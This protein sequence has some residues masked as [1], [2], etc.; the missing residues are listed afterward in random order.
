MS[1][2]PALF[3]PVRLGDD[4]PGS[5]SSGWSEGAGSFEGMAPGEQVAWLPTD[6]ARG[7]WDPGACHGG[8]P[9][10]LLTRELESVPSSSPMR[11][12]RVTVELVRP[13]PLRPLRATASIVRPG[14]RI[15]LLDAE[16][17]TVDDDQLVAMARGLRMR[18]TEVGSVELD[19]VGPGGPV[20]HG[21]GDRP[22]PLPEVADDVGDV[23][24]SY[25]AFHNRAT[26]HRFVRGSFRSPGPVFDWVRLVVPVVV[27]EDPSPWQRAAATAD[28]ANGIASSV[29]FDPSALFINPDLTVHL[30]REPVGEWIGMESVMRTSTTGIGLS[31]SAM[32]DAEGRIGRCN[33]SLLLD[34]R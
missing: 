19:D 12:A 8:P 9:A 31:D 25:R 33:Q 4:A 1:A 20:A 18:V 26:E 6:F 21:V 16:L 27:G 28:F 7:P 2:A 10:A 11:L 34:R 13:V 15:E 32:W 5:D 3:L 17:R 22:L 29:D 14:R 23:M 24:V 30:W